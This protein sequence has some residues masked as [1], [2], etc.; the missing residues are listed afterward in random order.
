MST[1][2]TS[3]QVV[4]DNVLICLKEG[5][6][7]PLNEDASKSWGVP[8]GTLSCY[9]TDL[10]KQ[11]WVFELIHGKGYKITK[12]TKS[13]KTLA[14]LRANLVK[15]RAAKALKRQQTQHEYAHKVATKWGRVSE[16]PKWEMILGL[17]VVNTASFIVIALKLVGI[18]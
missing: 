15:A 2:H 17:Q 12:P 8:I 13:S 1:I 11:G 18:I 6:L 14:K 10:R 9:L 7:L 3:R 4:T 16:L 5:S